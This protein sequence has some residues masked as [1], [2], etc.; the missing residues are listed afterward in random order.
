[1][2]R[3]R[4]QT[5]LRLDVTR[6]GLISRLAIGGS[7]LMSKLFWLTDDQ[8]RKIEPQILTKDM[9]RNKRFDVVFA[10]IEDFGSAVLLL[11]FLYDR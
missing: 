2:S 9:R 11:R 4:L 10:R 8:W 5:Q 7:K 3:F 6:A 1:M